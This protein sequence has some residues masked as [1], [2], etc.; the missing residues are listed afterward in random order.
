MSATTKYEIN[1]KV[2]KGG[3]MISV[4]KVLKANAEISKLM[5]KA[6]LINIS[7]EDKMKYLKQILK[8]QEEINIYITGKVSGIIT[9]K[10]DVMSFDLSFLSPDRLCFDMRWYI[11]KFLPFKKCVGKNYY[12]Y[13][14]PVMID[15]WLRRAVNTF[16]EW[17]TNAKRLFLI[18]NIVRPAEEGDYNNWEELKYWV[19]KKSSDDLNGIIYYYK[20]RDVIGSQYHYNNYFEVRN[21]YG[22]MRALM[23]TI[24]KEALAGRIMYVDKRIYEIQN[25]MK[26]KKKFK[27]LVDDIKKK[28]NE[29]KYMGLTIS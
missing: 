19:M 22:T 27:G 6:E 17:T 9:I 1:R 15:E 14:C 18:N 20:N 16:S 4:D 12:H 21:K 29:T 3:E 2:G 28:W 11:Q 5:M 26:G 23:P 7:N 10:K 8:K 13:D 25:T 24:S